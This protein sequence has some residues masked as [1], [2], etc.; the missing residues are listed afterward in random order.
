MS[1]QFK[2]KVALVTGGASGI[3]RATALAFA[4]EKATVVVAD[5]NDSEGQQTVDM[6][7]KSGG[8]ALFVKTDV[9]SSSEVKAM[10]TTTVN[11]YGRLDFAFNNAGI[12]GTPDKLINLS[13]ENWDKVIGINQKGV[14]LCMKYE[15]R[16]M[17]QQRSGAIVNTASTAG[18]VGLK[19]CIAYGASKHAVVGMTKSA[20]LEYATTGIRINAVCPRAVR[21][22]LTNNQIKENPKLEDYYTQIEPIGRM[23]APEEIAAAVIWLCSD[24]ASFV[25]G[26]AMAVDGGMTT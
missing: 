14:W 4:G 1:D 13:E 20:A 11:A 15:I 18:L 6:I 19:N 21:T 17:I 10:V 8:E 26:L 23:G 9:S 16:Q 22:A 3:G 2:G 5:M 25:T 24:A 12:F 7:K